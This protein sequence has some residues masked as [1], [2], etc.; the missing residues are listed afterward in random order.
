MSRA[1]FVKGSEQ[2]DRDGRG[3]DLAGF[4]TLKARYVKPEDGNLPATTF[5]EGCGQYKTFKAGKSVGPVVSLK[6]A[7]SAVEERGEWFFTP[8]VLIYACD[9]C[10]PEKCE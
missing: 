8:V 3:H 10:A 2:D 9:E 6:S 7:L 5:I 1:E 4:K